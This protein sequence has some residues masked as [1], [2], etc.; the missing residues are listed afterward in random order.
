MEINLLRGCRS[1]CISHGSKYIKHSLA[2]W[3]REGMVPFYFALVSP[4]LKCC[5]QV[6]VPQDENDIK[7]LESNQRRVTVMVKG[8]DGKLCKDRLRSFSLFSLEKRRLRKQDLFSV[9][10]FFVRGSRR[11]GTDLFSLMTSDRT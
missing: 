1:S 8:L 9:Y 6:W 2:S 11:A 5:V 3:L 7:L 4:H 10:S